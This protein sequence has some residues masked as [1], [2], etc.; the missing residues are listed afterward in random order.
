[1]KTPLIRECYANLECR[2]VDARLVRK[3]NFF[4]FEMV[5]AHVAT[6]PR[7]PRTLQYLG[8]GLFFVSRPIIGR[9]ARF[10]GELLQER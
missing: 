7:H 3:Y 10:R 2:L 4:L 5:K 9:R 8:D 6:S 1:V